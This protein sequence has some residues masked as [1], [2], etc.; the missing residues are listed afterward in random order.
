LISVEVIMVILTSSLCPHQKN[1]VILSLHTKKLHI[2]DY[3][4]YFLA[5]YPLS[6]FPQGGNGGFA[7]SPVGEGWEGGNRLKEEWSTYL[8]SAFSNNMS[9]VAKRRISHKYKQLFLQFFNLSN[10]TISSFTEN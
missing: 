1:H 6:Y 5:F 9:F 7:P 4:K 2:W 8:N 3:D 10:F